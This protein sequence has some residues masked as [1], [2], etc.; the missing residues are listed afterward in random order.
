MLVARGALHFRPGFIL[1]STSLRPIFAEMEGKT[2]LFLFLL[3]IARGVMVAVLSL[4]SFVSLPLAGW[5]ETS[6][7]NYV[8][9][10]YTWKK[11]INSKLNSDLPPTSDE[12]QVPR[13]ACFFRQS[14]STKFDSKGRKCCRLIPLA[15]GLLQAK[16]YHHQ[17]CC[18][19]SIN[20]YSTKDG[21]GYK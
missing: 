15:L 3:D 2:G 16:H 20:S 10:S 4:S 12:S 11:S 9:Y 14:H 13:R 18:F 19:N 21:N 17:T 7:Q 8:F 6:A 1:I 5:R